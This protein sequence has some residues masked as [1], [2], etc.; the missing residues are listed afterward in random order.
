MILFKKITKKEI[1]SFVPRAIKKKVYQFEETRGPKME[2]V[3][4]LIH[5]NFAVCVLE[6]EMK[7]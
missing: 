2:F 7:S 6:N 5:A 4:H 1:A 3:S